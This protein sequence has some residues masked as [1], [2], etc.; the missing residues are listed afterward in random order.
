MKDLICE[1]REWVDGVYG[2]YMDAV[3]GFP[4]VRAEREKMKAG[5]W[6]APVESSQAAPSTGS[7]RQIFAY[8]RLVRGGKADRPT[9]IHQ[10]DMETA[11]E[12]NAF[13][14]KN[15][16]FVGRMAIVAIYGHWND[17]TRVR[18]EE[19]LGWAKDSLGVPIMGDVRH[20]R[21]MIV[22][23]RSLADARVKKLEVLAW[24]K[25]GETISPSKDNIEDMTDRIM[26]FLGKF[27]HDPEAYHKT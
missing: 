11:I 23:N 19:Q 22:H 8:A 20:I 14:G 1:F 9:H 4:L 16:V 2:T 18:I 15:T 24:P 6:P 26:E 3:S 10:V 21:D 5:T 7:G 27:E 13:L 25:E 17:H 12:R